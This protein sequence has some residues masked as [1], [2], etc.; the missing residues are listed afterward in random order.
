MANVSTASIS[1]LKSHIDTLLPLTSTFT[2]ITA[3]KH[4]ALQTEI[5][6]RMDSRIIEIGSISIYSGDGIYNNGFV[7]FQNT[8][9]DTNYMVTL[10]NQDTVVITSSILSKT[11][12]G[13]TWQTYQV[14]GTAANRIL[15]YMVLNTNST[16]NDG[17]SLT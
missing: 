5:V 12:T 1:L 8:T 16:I 17:R 9:A 14:S 4:K 3:V 11:T 10:V 6:D 2:D 15:N 13:F 7:T